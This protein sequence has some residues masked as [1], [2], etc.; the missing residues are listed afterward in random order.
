[1]TTL[2]EARLKSGFSMSDVARTS[3]ASKGYLS[4][5]ENGIIK[6]PSF[7]KIKRLCKLYGVSMY[8]IEI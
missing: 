3:I 8:D 4:G 2:R 1:M 6:T 7:T 5:V